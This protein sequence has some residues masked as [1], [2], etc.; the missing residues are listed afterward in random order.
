MGLKKILLTTIGLPGLIFLVVAVWLAAAD[1]FFVQ[2]AERATGFVVGM[3][4]LKTSKRRAKSPLIQFIT[5]KGDTVL[6]ESGVASTS[7]SMQKGDS[8]A[9]F[10]D[11]EYPDRATLDRF[12]E[13]W[14]LPVIF[15]GVGGVLISVAL[16]LSRIQFK[17]KDGSPAN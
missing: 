4:S 11:P 12:T 1:Y 2:K 15:G 3:K 7:P 6:V 8:V 14:L 17:R 5:V 16:I 13:R 10:Y 9:V